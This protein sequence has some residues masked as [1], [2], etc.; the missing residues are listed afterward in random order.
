MAHIINLK[1][2]GDPR[3]NLTVIEKIVPFD[4]KRV[5]YIYGVPEEDIVRAGHKHKKN[6]QALICV[7]GSCIISNNDGKKKEDFI[8]DSP[9]KLLIMNPED[10][11][12]MHHFTKDA[13]L[14]VLASEYYDKDDYIDTPYN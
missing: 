9:N 8:L 3:G 5:Y 11:H 1:S 4:I 6:I 10:W 13:V 14:L 12:T 2:F 7:S